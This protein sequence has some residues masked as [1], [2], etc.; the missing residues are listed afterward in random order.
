MFSINL[1]NI[2]KRKKILA[3]LAIESFSVYKTHI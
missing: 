3:G 2:L 1:K